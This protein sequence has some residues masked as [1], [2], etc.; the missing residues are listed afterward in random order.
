MGY[1]LWGD[2]EFDN[3]F[4]IGKGLVYGDIFYVLVD[5]VVVIFGLI[6]RFF[7]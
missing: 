5:V 2:F 3:V 6:F 1:F 7:C 4:M